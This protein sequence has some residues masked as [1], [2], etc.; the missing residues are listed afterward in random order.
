MTVNSKIILKEIK[1]DLPTV[2]IIEPFQP[3]V[4]ECE[5]VEDFSEI[6]NANKEKYNGYTTQ[7][8]NKTFKIPGYKV[9]KINGEI[10]LR[11]IKPCEQLNGKGEHHKQK[12]NEEINNIK[13]AFNQLSEQFDTIK[14][15][16]IDNGL[17]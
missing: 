7:K 13:E 9:T 5:N 8:L 6:I 3:E 4:I 15:I 11:S 12:I 17:L 1:K 2:K 14:Q 16:L 10:S